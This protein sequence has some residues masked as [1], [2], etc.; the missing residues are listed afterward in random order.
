MSQSWWKEG[1]KTIFVCILWR[2]KAFCLGVQEIKI[3]DGKKG[4]G[5][6]VWNFLFS[7]V[8]A[9]YIDEFRKEN[10]VRKAKVKL[11]TC[12]VYRLLHVE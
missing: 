8:V 9:S 5:F 3:D 2:K 4:S 12:G 1:N 11:C 10:L 6:F 7:F